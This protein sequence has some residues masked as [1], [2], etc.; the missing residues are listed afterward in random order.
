MAMR[1]SFFFT[2]AALLVATV[3]HADPASDA[4]DLFE[5]ARQ[6][7]A[8]GK[9]AEAAP[10]FEKAATVY[11]A[12]L[13]SIRNAAECE[14]QLGHFATSH[15]LWLDLKRAVMLSKDPKYAGWQ[16]DAEGAAAR[17]APKLARVTVRLT[18]TGT[19]VV[20]RIND[21]VVAPELI[22]APLERDP[23][24][25]VVRVTSDGQPPAEQ[26]VQMAA[27]DAKELT[28]TIQA[29]PPPTT[30]PPDPTVVG[31]DPRHDPIP[32]HH[33]TPPSTGAATRRTVGW[34]GVGVGA[35]ALVGAGISLGIRQAALGDLQSGCPKY[36]TEKCPTNLQSTVTRGATASTLVN[37]LGIAG[38][39]V[40]LTG[41]LL[42]VLS[43]QAPSAAKE[44][45]SL[46]PEVSVGLGA[47][48]ARWSF[49]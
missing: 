21:E 37:V 30:P 7:R 41:V 27:G 28:F 32:E 1:A 31:P 2:I 20:V 14:E 10:L 8:A 46:T 39:I 33:E 44:K 29:P 25:Y 45:A 47:L 12:G 43:P 18:N 15:R 5:R 42:V 6:L 38:G 16:A 19:N 26:T 4:K 34:V 3:A 13:G 24:R 35:A 11:P 36:L 22:G 40:G 23:G 17:L 9:C 48:S 49:Q